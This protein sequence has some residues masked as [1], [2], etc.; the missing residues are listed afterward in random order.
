MLEVYHN[1]HK[2]YGVDDIKY[3]FLDLLDTK[4]GKE[5]RKERRKEK[6]SKND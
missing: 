6:T 3:K 5:R 4:I 2:I 1:D